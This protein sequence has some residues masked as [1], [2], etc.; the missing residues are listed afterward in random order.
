MIRNDR[1]M[2]QV[3][4][5]LPW[6]HLWPTRQINLVPRVFS[7]NEVACQL[8]SFSCLRTTTVCAIF[9]SLFCNSF[10]VVNK[11][12]PFETAY[13]VLDQITHFRLTN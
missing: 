9:N 5:G 6:S 13:Q 1:P 3:T 2:I 11:N 7:Y 12:T 10:K 4:L 8:R